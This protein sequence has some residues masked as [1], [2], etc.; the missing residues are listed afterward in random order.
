MFRSTLL[1]ILCLMMLMDA[2]RG[3]DRSSLADSIAINVLVLPDRPMREH[4][5]RLNRQ[6]RANDP[7]GFA[8]DDSH[9]PHLSLLHIY[10]RSDDLPRVIEAVSGVLSRHPVVGMSLEAQ[11]LEH[12]PWS[13][14]EMSSVAVRKRTEL[15]QVQDALVTALRPFRTPSADA[16]AFVGS[17][18]DDATVQYVAGF[19]ENQTGRKFKPHITVGLS[20]EDFAER[21]RVGQAE[22]GPADSNVETVA[23]YQL[24]NA[25]TARKE[26]WRAQ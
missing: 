22:V 3:E 6:L 7:Q 18:V 16:T 15:T 1:A 25:G 20:D 11:G 10:V 17:D 9:V 23:I 24:G 5:Q 26:L 8:L 4:V 14:R 13:G 21:L 19:I 12:Q 2:A